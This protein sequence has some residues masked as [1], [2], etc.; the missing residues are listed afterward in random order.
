MEGGWFLNG[1]SLTNS[2]VFFENSS[3]SNEVFNS[4]FFTGN[5]SFGLENSLG[6]F[7]L[8]PASPSDIL[9]ATLHWFQELTCHFFHTTSSTYGVYPGTD[10]NAFNDTCDPRSRD[11]SKTSVLSCNRMSAGMQDKFDYFQCISDKLHYKSSK[12]RMKSFKCVKCNMASDVPQF[13]MSI[14]ILAGAGF[15][16]FD[17]KTRAF[18]TDNA[19]WA[20]FPR[21][22]TSAVTQSQ[23]S[24]VL[25]VVMNCRN[26]EEP[27]NDQLLMA[28]HGNTSY[29]DGFNSWSDVFKCSVQNVFFGQDDS[30][31][32]GSPNYEWSFV[33]VL[34]FILAGGL[35]NILVCLAVCL[36]TRLQNVT[37]YFLLSLA[38]ADLLVSLFVMPLGAIPGFLGE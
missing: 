14:N 21:V 26:V 6:N 37:N 1:F 19:F 27:A 12:S 5:S 17:D 11:S 33:F 29:F 4:S 13:K 32:D 30:S 28:L 18:R 24:E 23:L 22:V 34:V 9:N 2:T 7:Y 10:M 20:K 36:D 15:A 25:Q 8:S 3:T 16:L 31:V 35:G 38:L